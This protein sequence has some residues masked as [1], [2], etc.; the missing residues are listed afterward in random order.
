MSGER[1]PFSIFISFKNHD[2]EGGLTRD[3]ELAEGLYRALTARGA[4]VFFSLFTLKEMGQAEY[5]RAINAALDQ[6][7]VLVVVGTSAANVRSRWVEYE[8]SSFHDDI[9]SGRKPNGTMLSYIEGISSGE[10]PRE[11]RSGYEKI[12]ADRTTPDEAAEFILRCAGERENE[13]GAAS[14]PADEVSWSLSG[15]QLLEQPNLDQEI[16]NAYRDQCDIDSLDDNSDVSSSF[17]IQDV[18]R[19]SYINNY[20]TRFCNNN[21]A[22]ETKNPCLKVDN[23]TIDIIDLSEEG[24][25]GKHFSIIDE[26]DSKTL[27]FEVYECADFGTKTRFYQPELLDCVDELLDDGRTKRTYYVEDAQPSG[28]QLVFITFMFKDRVALTNAGILIGDEVRL[29]KSPSMIRFG[30]SSAKK[31]SAHQSDPAHE[32]GESMFTNSELRGEEVSE[33]LLRHTANVSPDVP[34]IIDSTDASLVLREL[35]WD[36]DKGD[37]SAHIDI[38]PHRSYY[39]LRIS[40]KATERV[41]APLSDY[42]IAEYYLEGR[43]AF[44]RDIM[45]ACEYFQSD[46]SPKALLG[47][48]HAFS[49]DSG[50]KNNLLAN[51]YLLLAANA[52]S[53]SAAVELAVKYM[54]GSAVTDI[55]ETGVFAKLLAASESDYRPASML[56]AYCMEKGIFSAVNLSQS[57]ELYLKLTQFPYNYLPAQMRLDRYWSKRTLSKDQL[58]TAFK[59]SA[60]HPLGMSE[61]CI[62][63]SLLHGSWFF[64]KDVTSGVALLE[65]SVSQGGLDAAYELFQLY[66]D[67][68]DE[69]FDPAKATELG[70]LLSGSRHNKLVTIENWFSDGRSTLSNVDADKVA[71]EALTL[72]A[73]DDSD[74][75]A[76]NNLG[77]MYLHGRGC[78]LDYN[79]AR[80]CF[81]RA[82]EAGSVMSV[83]HLGRLYEQGL[84]VPADAQY[85]IDL[86]REAVGRGCGLAERRLAEI[87]CE[88]KS[89]DDC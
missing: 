24:E 74:S 51:K 48:S 61:F 18:L 17:S 2:H 69:L 32:L 80:L 42:E 79:S 46:G 9:L 73:T 20:I 81:E 25:S 89:S 47:I 87:T 29:T 50:Y 1:Q 8:W 36:A 37:Y 54:F 65:S 62:G 72:A 11:L 86:Y 56:L 4:Q 76:L 33:M 70:I 15:G 23:D 55:D 57:F 27:V 43:C 59:S 31:P 67:E 16:E 52:G 26:R 71:F 13:R 83:Y 75:T 88:S 5:K 49:A 68:S 44:P 12:A 77:W 7:S 64:H 19:E 3:R 82:K 45:R 35:E 41:R 39:V 63:S 84:G 10:L 28:N 78:A 40:D 34:V 66:S 60:E 30:S 14:S 58:W 22:S 21:V 53:E 85:A 38:V 6:A